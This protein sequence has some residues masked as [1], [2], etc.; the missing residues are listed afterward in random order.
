MALTG[1]ERARP[2]G[3]SRKG[4]G[5]GSQGRPAGC[6]ELSGSLAGAGLRA[7]GPPHLAPLPAIRTSG[8]PLTPQKAPCCR[9][10]HGCLPQSLRGPSPYILAGRP[11]RAGTRPLPFG[12]QGAALARGGTQGPHQT[13]PSLPWLL[14]EGAPGLDGALSLPPHLPDTGIRTIS[15]ERPEGV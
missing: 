12:Q 11:G 9:V 14:P 10:E 7:S 8:D 3:C 2:W 1:G 4:S 15:K 13:Q 6:R 5:L